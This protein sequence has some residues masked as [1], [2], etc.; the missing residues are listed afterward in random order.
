MKPIIVIVGPTASGKSTLAIQLASSYKGEIIAAD[1]RTVYKGMDIGTAKPSLQ[2]KQQVPHFGMDLIEPDRSYSAA[3]FKIYATRTIRDIHERNKLPIVV[4]GTGLYVDGLVYDFQFGPAADP[5]IRTHLASL[6]LNELRILAAQKGIN[7]EQVN[8]ANPRH[9]SRAIERG[10][11]ARQRIGLPASILLI[12]LQIDRE[13]LHSRIEERVGTMF[14]NGL[15]EEV[16]MTIK[17]YEPDAP[18][19]L[20]P[21][22]KAVKDYLEGN[23]TL[24]ESKEQFIR[25]DKRLAKRQMTWFKRNKDINWCASEHE[26]DELTR[27]FLATFATIEP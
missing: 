18:A 8:Y 27:A 21:G 17:R 19:L 15:V 4:G 20:A 12:G 22:Y 23:L 11:T 5:A 1:S 25:N 2:E 3:E 7:P 6:N 10:G 24:E 14:N 16:K 9:L 26:A 13:Q